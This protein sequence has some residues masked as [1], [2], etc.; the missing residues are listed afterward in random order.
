MV[1]LTLLDSN[2]RLLSLGL[3]FLRLE[4]GL[5]V[6]GVVGSSGFEGL[7]APPV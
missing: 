1:D 4:S 5:S 2:L 3:W 7:W 6:P